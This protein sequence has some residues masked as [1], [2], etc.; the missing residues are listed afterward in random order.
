MQ[1]MQE[2]KREEMDMTAKRLKN[3][4][5][6][7]ISVLRIKK[8]QKTMFSLNLAPRWFNNRADLFEACS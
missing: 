6:L 8:K 7:E 5:L 3:D 4:Q 1:K 2:R